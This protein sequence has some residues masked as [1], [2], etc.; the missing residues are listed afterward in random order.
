MTYN[1]IFKELQDEGVPLADIKV[2][3]D[4]YF[5]VDFNRLGIIGNDDKV[6]NQEYNDLI[7]K[8][9]EGYPIAYLVGYTDILSLHILL[10]EDTLIPR[11]ETADFI[12]S[13][14]RDNYDFNYKKIFPII[15]Y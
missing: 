8:I 15:I 11:I 4:G 7:A 6:S 2:I 10:N 13:Y 9:K 14:I 3:F 5:K 1:E 12:Y